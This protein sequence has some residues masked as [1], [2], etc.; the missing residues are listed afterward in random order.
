MIFFLMYKYHYTVY[1]Y[2][3][4]KVNLSSF[5]ARLPGNFPVAGGSPLDS[6]TTTIFI[7]QMMMN[8]GVGEDSIIFLF[9]NPDPIFMINFAK[10]CSF[11]L[12]LEARY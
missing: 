4:I 6:E 5:L 7:G 8:H 9:P 3:F 12:I 11:Y 1:V 2:L 10:Q